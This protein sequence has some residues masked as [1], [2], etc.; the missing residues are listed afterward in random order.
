LELREENESIEKILI[1]KD[2]VLLSL[3]GLDINEGIQKP[4]VSGMYLYERVTF[5]L[6]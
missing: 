3:I 1:I 2:V 4:M 6:P 5:K